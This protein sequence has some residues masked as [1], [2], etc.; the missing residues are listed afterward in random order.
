MPTWAEL[1]PFALLGALGSVHCI[2]MC[3]LFAV[4][5][6]GGPVA[7]G[8]RLAAYVAGK[9]ATYAVLG[10]V[11][12]SATALT[13]RSSH[14]A[15]LHGLQSAL[16]WLAGGALVVSGFGW[17]LVRWRGRLPVPRFLQTAGG[18][19][20]KTIA[21]IRTLPGTSG[22]LGTGVLTGAL[23]GGLSWSALLLASQHTP[24]QASLGMLTFGLATGPALVMTAL[25]WNALP[26][27]VRAL[28]TRF[29][30]VLCILLGVLVI[31]RGG[32]PAELAPIERVLPDCCSHGDT[33]TSP[34]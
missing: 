12:A 27:R 7:R 26:V 33:S 17:M 30:G 6:A 3:G 10:V 11:V 14:A 5:A 29:A 16:A 31:A 1:L 18:A 22:A 21:L 4:A 20:R 13:L 34:P 8:R 28:G 9:A 2:G 19:A 24:A 15:G 25:G 23:P 32:L